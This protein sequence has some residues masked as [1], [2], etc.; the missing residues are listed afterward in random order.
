MATETDIVD[1]Q[2]R[3][4]LGTKADVGALLDVLGRL[5]ERTNT[6]VRLGLG[7][8]AIREDGAFEGTGTGAAEYVAAMGSLGAIQDLLAQGHGTN[9]E[10]F[11]R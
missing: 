6:Y 5:S 10:K 7:D 11:A 4:V 2:R 9:L 3:V 8:P 1:Q